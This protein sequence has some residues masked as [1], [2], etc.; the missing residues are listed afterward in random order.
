MIAELDRDV[1]EVPTRPSTLTNTTNEPLERT[2]ATAATVL[3]VTSAFFI[4]PLFPYANLD[5]LAGAGIAL[6]IGSALAWIELMHSA[7]AGRF[8]KYFPL[9]VTILASFLLTFTVINA[10]GKYV[11]SQTR[12]AIIE[13]EMLSVS[14]RRSDLPEIFQALG[15]KISN[16]ET[17]KFPPKPMPVPMPMPKIAPATVKASQN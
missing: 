6:A 3:A 2:F 17:V 12:C 16:N 5:H 14:P 8:T 15:C 10:M 1:E 4:S 13:K 11:Q 9:G 7:R